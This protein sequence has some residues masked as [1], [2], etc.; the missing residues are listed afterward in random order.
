MVIVV[1]WVFGLCF[2]ASVVGFVLWVVLGGFG[3]FTG[4]FGWVWDECGLS[5]VPLGF[6]WLS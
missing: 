3:W 4:G 6:G 2:L 1:V 5:V